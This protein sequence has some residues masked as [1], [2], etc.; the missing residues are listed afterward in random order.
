LGNV[1]CLNTTSET[2]EEDPNF[3]RMRF[4]IDTL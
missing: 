3:N 4:L 1:G 2:P